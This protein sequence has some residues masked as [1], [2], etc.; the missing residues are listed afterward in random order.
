MSLEDA[1]PKIF[2]YL[3]VDDRAQIIGVS[4]QLNLMRQVFF[5]IKRAVFMATRD[6]SYKKSVLALWLLVK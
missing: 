5:L 3:R 6:H 4:C 2:Q 1:T